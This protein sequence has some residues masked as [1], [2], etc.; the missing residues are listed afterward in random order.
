MLK[1]LEKAINLWIVFFFAT[2]VVEGVEG[3]AGTFESS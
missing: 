3:G 2:V 1:Y